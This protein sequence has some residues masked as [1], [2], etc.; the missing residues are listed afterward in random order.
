MVT[1]M[2]SPSRR[3]LSPRRLRLHAASLMR[4]SATSVCSP[5]ARSR[6][7]MPSGDRSIRSTS[8]R[9]IRACSAGN[10]SSHSGAKVGDGLDNLALRDLDF[11]LRRRPCPG[12]DLGRPQ[13]MADLRDDGLL[14]FRRRHAP[15]RAF[16]IAPADG[17]GGD[18]VAVELA[19]LARM[20]RRH[21]MAAGSEDQALEQRRRLRSRRVAASDGVLGED[22][23]HLVPDRAVDDRLMLAGVARALVHR[24]AEVNAVV[25]DLVDRALVDRLARPVL[26]VL[27]RPALRRMAGAA[28]SCASFVAEPTRRNRLKIS[29][30]SSASVSFTT[31]LRSTTS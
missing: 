7:C 8:S 5:S 1:V 17:V 25:Q 22:G 30:T 31:S 13:Q 20:R 10:N 15:H 28:S 2:V 24:L 26:A 23:V 19:V 6:T 29:R 4:S 27:R 3:Q 16:R 14:D 12:D 21:R 18:V 11:A 9:T